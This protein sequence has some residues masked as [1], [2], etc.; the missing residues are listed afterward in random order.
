[1]IL[2]DE[3]KERL[4]SEVQVTATRSSGPGGQNVNKVSTKIEL[5]FMVE[6]SDILTGEEKQLIYNKLKNRISMHGELIL[7]SSA[8]R[9]QWRNRE[10]AEQKFVELIQW[11]LTK[12]RRRKKTQPTAASR[13]KRIENKKQHA[14]KKELRKPLK[15]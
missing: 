3:K 7:T 10:K 6:A 15:F 11:A 9:S 13:Q 5:R 1:M 12:P 8:E 2:S 14:Q 4:L